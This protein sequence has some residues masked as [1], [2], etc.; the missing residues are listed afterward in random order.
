MFVHANNGCV[1]WP[2]EVN[3]VQPD[4]STTTVTIYITY[5]RLTRTE[6]RARDEEIIAYSRQF[7]LLVPADGESDTD[8]LRAKR[9]ALSDERTKADDDRLRTRVKG[10]SNIGDIE[11]N[12][13]AFTAQALEA[14]IDD[15]LLRD[16]LLSGLLDASVGAKAKNSS[17][18]LA[19]YPEPVQA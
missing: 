14:F 2:V 9:V 12:P 6:Q 10:W 17:P 1:R 19:G 8:D 15:S 4:G 5:Q 11:G 16:T 7:R 3:Q 18:G 13:L